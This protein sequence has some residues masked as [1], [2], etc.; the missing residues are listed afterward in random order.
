[1]KKFITIL[2][3]VFFV[4]PIFGFQN[5]F[6]FVAEK[7]PGDQELVLYV[8][9][10]DWGASVDK[11]VVNTG[12]E[13]DPAYFTAEDFRLS[14]FEVSREVRTQANHNV[15]ASLSEDELEPVAAYIS[16]GLG[17][18]TDKKSKF[19]T[20]TFS[21]PVDSKL[22]TP[23]ATSAVLPVHEIYGYRVEN[24]EL[25]FEVYKLAGLV[26]SLAA[27]FKISQLISSEKKMSYA[28]YKPQ[29]TKD[30]K[31]I[32]LIIWLHGISE[33]GENPFLPMLGIKSV[34][35]AGD[36]IQDYFENGAAVLLPQ[37]PVA[38]VLTTDVDEN[39][40]RMWEPVDI[41]GTKNK[42]VEPFKA[43]AKI[44]S[45]DQVED[46]KETEELYKIQAKTSFY[47]ED[48]MDLIGTFLSQNPDIDRDRIYIGGCSAGGY[49]TVNM[50]IEKP[51]FFAAAF[52]TCEIYLD[53]K[54]TNA[55]IEL[56]SK[57]PLWF[58]QASND[59]TAKAKNCITPTYKRL[60][61]AGA[62]DLHLTMYDG[63]FGKDGTEYP[64]HWSWIY[65]LNNEAGDK[66]QKLFQWLASQKR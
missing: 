11:I 5:D 34:N 42:I 62:K 45:K 19:V 24:D 53:S 36:E 29:K 9:A 43:L 4:F 17:N 26:N 6:S 61:A 3:A 20:L 31:K 41:A 21:Y 7:V 54:I 52:P 50:L 28:F 57:V 27:R 18:K 40:I 39:G 33:G 30:S 59:E 25:D 23:L 51:G 1:M 10:N 48:L 47:T 37:C 14:D 44:F 64:G 2:A 46:S 49:M 58:V 13:I 55:D 32:P 35:L 60:E 16:D 63:V 65:T 12:K 8:T 15:R 66:E 22:A 38:W 56:L